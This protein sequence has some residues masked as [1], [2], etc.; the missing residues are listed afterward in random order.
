MK[1]LPLVIAVAGAITATISNQ[2]LNAERVKNRRTR[3]NDFRVQRVR[4]PQQPQQATLS[5]AQFMKAF[6]KA[7]AKLSKR[8]R[9][10]QKFNRMIEKV[11]SYKY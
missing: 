3:L 11:E 9:A 4:R 10:M 7:Q 8:R 6:K 2:A 5:L 1:L